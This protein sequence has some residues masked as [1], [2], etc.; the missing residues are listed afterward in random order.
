MENID[1][2]KKVNVDQI[3]KN[4]AGKVP[5]ILNA[6]K[7]QSAIESKSDIPS[8]APAQSTNS[9]WDS[10]LVV[11]TTP[12]IAQPQQIGDIVDK[13]KEEQVREQ[14]IKNDDREQD[15]RLKKGSLIALFVLLSVE[16]FVIFSFALFQ[17]TSLFGFK[18]EEWSFKLL[19]SAT[20]TQITIMLMVAI[21]YLFPSK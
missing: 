21:K 11:S 9:S 12:T 2:S 15:K 16:T 6:Q 14:S 5:D 1:L 7:E 3:L 8:P 18:L 17:A 10:S 4:L 13:L 19:I 20:I